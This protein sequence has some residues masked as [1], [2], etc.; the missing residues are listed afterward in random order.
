MDRPIG[1]TILAGLAVLLA[2]INAIAM[3]RFLGFL[4]FLGVLDIRIFNFWYA[5]MY[6]L[7]AYIWAWVAQMLWQVDPQA[8]LFLAV[9]AVFNLCLAFVVL[10]TGGS[11]YDINLSVIINALIL[12][13]VM[14]PGV[15]EAFGRD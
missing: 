4:P 2:F 9:I 5:L 13:Y 14:L 11:W 12:I 3:L 6:G 7:L 1:V 8:W 15:R 10:V